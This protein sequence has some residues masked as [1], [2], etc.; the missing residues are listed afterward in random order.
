[1]LLTEHAL[2]CFR[3]PQSTQME[4]EKPFFAAV[5]Q[6]FVGGRKVYFLKPAAAQKARSVLSSSAAPVTGLS[7][8]QAA[9]LAK[10][11]RLRAQARHDWNRAQV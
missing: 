11:N 1:M 6:A 5:Q 8:K 3:P 7:A 2:R 4:T 10:I 9:E